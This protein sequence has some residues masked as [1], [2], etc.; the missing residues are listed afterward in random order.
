MA[1]FLSF[2]PLNHW[3]EDLICL[4]SC[5][6]RLRCCKEEKKKVQAP[7]TLSEKKHPC[8]PLVQLCLGFVCACVCVCDCLICCLF[9][10]FFSTLFYFTILYWF[11]HTLTWLFIVLIC[12]FIFNWRIIALQYCVGL[13]HTSAWISHRHTYVPSLPPHPTPL[14]C[15]R[16]PGLSSLR[17][18]ANS[19]WLAIL[20]TVMYMFPCCCL[21]SSP[22]LHPPLHS[23]VCSL[24]LHLHCC[25]ANRFISSLS[26]DSIYTHWYMKFGFLFLAY[27][28]RY[29][30]L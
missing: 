29:N 21:N 9:L 16:A 14:G 27:F 28:T 20:H 5:A 17:H 26:L 24:C 1:S 12:K 11:C 19:H 2:S 10:N 4:S 30:R 13:C 6:K 8:A 18:T 25:P 15:H 7:E 3:S 23:Q 22:S